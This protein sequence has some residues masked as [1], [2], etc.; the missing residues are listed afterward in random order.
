MRMFEKKFLKAF[1]YRGLFLYFIK[2]NIL[3]FII[4]FE[5]LFRI[6][7]PH[8]MGGLV[9]FLCSDDAL[10]ITGETIVA[11]GGMSSRL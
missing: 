1:R 3:Y 5:S 4:Y 8:E 9:S 6:G 10:Y 2:S 7:Q 11:S